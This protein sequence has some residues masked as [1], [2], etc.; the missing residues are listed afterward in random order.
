MSRRNSDRRNLLE[1]HIPIV[2]Q[3]SNVTPAVLIASYLLEFL[4]ALDEPALAVGLLLRTG[5]GV[6]N[7]VDR[8]AGHVA[9]ALAL[10]FS[11]G[12]HCG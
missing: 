10:A 5:S 12:P 1:L 6:R 7:F 11:L 2:R 8:F 4:G 3:F 9:S